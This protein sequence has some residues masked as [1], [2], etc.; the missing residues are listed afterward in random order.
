MVLAGDIGGTKT[1][2]GLFSKGKR[3]P[4]LKAIETYPSR[5]ALNLE[6]IIEQFLAK[7]PVS[8]S[9]A[10]LG[11]AG[12]VENG[13]C[14]TTNLPWTVSER[15]IKNRFGWDKVRLINDLAATAWAVPV[16]TKSEFVALNRQR[17]ARGGNLGL[18]APGTGL[19]MALLVSK[20]GQYIPIP[21]EGGH[22]DFAPQSESE[23]ALW[24]YLNQ[25][26][27]HVSVERVLSGPGLFIIYCWL[28]YTG[29]GEEPAWLAEKMNENDPSKVIA[30]AAL[31]D[32]Q[33]LCVKTLNLFVS[34]F[35][36]AAGNLALTG[37]TT[38]GVYL[39]GGIP[40]KILPKLKEDV[41]MKA[42]TNKGRFRGLLGQI[43]V[44]V[45]MND[46]AALLG[47]ACCAF[48]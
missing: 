23:L 33:P 40:P 45:I 24:Q 43:P 13:L 1:N 46:K 41:F 20:D 34:I 6:Q 32:E 29:Q 26:V 31:V 12:P 36:A 2:L 44:R 39:G 38:G 7:H 22:S 48:E 28:K 15:K 37:L 3:R 25:R 9:S 17:P 42:F 19:G 8:I 11:I 14:K 21:S 18:I 27:G 5:K 35:G 4:L 47:A 16:L 30:E 10:C